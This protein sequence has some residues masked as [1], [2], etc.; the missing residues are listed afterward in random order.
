[1][2]A[3]SGEAAQVHDRSGVLVAAKE[4]G[5]VGQDCKLADKQR[6]VGCAVPAAGGAAFA[7]MDQSG[8]GCRAPRGGGAYLLGALLAGRAAD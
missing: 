8:A 7:L 2:T 3:G 5:L 6:T 4:G 1:L